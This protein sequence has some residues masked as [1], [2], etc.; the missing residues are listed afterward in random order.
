MPQEIRHVLFSDREVCEM[1]FDLLASRGD[2]RAIREPRVELGSDAQERPM[3]KLHYSGLDGRERSTLTLAG[4][5]ALGAAILY[6]RSHHV[7]LPMK[8]DKYLEIV[9]GY[10]ALVLS[11]GGAA[12]PRA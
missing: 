5:D 8:A 2:K 12:T 11:S 1:I 10:L 6:C 9:R 4:R 3:I 7:P